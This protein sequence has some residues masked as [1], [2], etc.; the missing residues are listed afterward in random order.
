MIFQAVEQRLREGRTDRGIGLMVAAGGR[1]L[2]Q[3]A[4]L[5]ETD[6]PEEHHAHHRQDDD[7]CKLL[8]HAKIRPGHHDDI[9]KPGPGTDEFR[10]DGADHSQN[11]G[12]LHAGKHRRQRLRQ[13]E[14]PESLPGI[15]AHRACQM[16]HF[17]RRGAK[18]TGSWR[19]PW[20]ADEVGEVTLRLEVTLRAG[21]LFPPVQA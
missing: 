20:A 10:D 2:G 5:D 18:A 3:N 14:A 1:V 16:Q 21:T 7:R 15:G 13:A 9:A 12:E 8:I 17:R 6:D 19:R 11:R 4:I